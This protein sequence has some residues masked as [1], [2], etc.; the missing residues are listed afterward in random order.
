MTQHL[1]NQLAQ[2]AREV[3]AL[4]QLALLNVRSGGGSTALSDELPVMA[5]TASA[6]VSTAAARGDHRHPT[7]TSRAAATH[8]HV[9]A[10]VSDFN[11]AVRTNKIHELA[12]PT[13]ATPMGS[14]KL[15][16]LAAG[17]AN[18][19]SVRYEQVCRLSDNQTVA[20]VKTFSS[21]PVLPAS[22]PTTD[23]QA[24]RKKYVDDSVAAVSGGAPTGAITAYAATTAPSG[25]LLCDGSVVAQATYPALYAL[26]GHSFG[27]D[28]GGGNF[29]LPDLRGRVPVG[30]DNLGGS[31][32]GRL[33]VA[34]T[35][36]GSGGAQ[37]HT[38]AANESGVPVHNHTAVL[39]NQAGTAN[40]LYS[41]GS[42]GTLA[43]IP[44]TG[45]SYR[46]GNATITVN[47]HSG[48]AAANAHNNMQPYQL[49]GYI[50]KT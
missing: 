48:S 25:W 20:G 9:A 14:Q 7:D 38:L 34:N 10:D 41:G 30:L 4:K 46:H 31:D 40:V 37:T 12:L 15:T 39:D 28:P 35:L 43:N 29:T 18:G 27:A 13:A 36:G 49:V 16:G 44:Q 11:T 33:S 17:S 5:G 1:E 24:A 19:D 3:A 47:N 45:A 22:N 21:I 32:A 50:I 23:N 2:L 42:G 26:I 8:G 6:G